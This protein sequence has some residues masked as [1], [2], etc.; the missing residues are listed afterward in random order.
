MKTIYQTIRSVELLRLSPLSHVRPHSV[1]DHGGS[2]CMRVISIVDPMKD[3]AHLWPLEHEHGQQSICCVVIF[4]AQQL[5][6]F[7]SIFTKISRL[8]PWSSGCGS[9]AV[10]LL[11]TFSFCF[12]QCAI[13]CY[14]LP[15]STSNPSQK[16]QD[17]PS[18]DLPCLSLMSAAEQGTRPPLLN[19][20]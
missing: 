15:Q 8:T 16:R 18:A 6:S 17:T 20:P 5:A 9:T 1:T 10:M 11:A 19:P 2:I 14:A 7:I 12:I 4:T 13:I 3:Y